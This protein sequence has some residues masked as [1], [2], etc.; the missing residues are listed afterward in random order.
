MKWQLQPVKGPISVLSDS[1]AT[2]ASVCQSEHQINHFKLQSGDGP[3][4]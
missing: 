3:M 4:Q 2:V 1:L